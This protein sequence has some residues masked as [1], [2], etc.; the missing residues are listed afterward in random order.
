MGLFVVAGLVFSAAALPVGCGGGGTTDGTGGSSSS[1]PQLTAGEE[2]C[3]TI[4]KYVNKCGSPSPCEQALVDDC[5]KVVDLLSDQFLRSATSCIL[6]GGSPIGCLGSSFTGLTPTEPQK[7][8]ASTF[9]E[10]C[11]GGLVPSCTDLFFGEGSVPEQLQ[12]AGKVILPLG[13][14]LVGKLETDCASAN[15]VTCVANFSNCAQATLVKQALPTN[16]VACLFDSLLNPKPEDQKPTCMISGTGGA[17]GGGSNSASSGTGTSTS[18]SSSS[19]GGNGC[20]TGSDCTQ[21]PDWNGCANCVLQKHLKGAPPYENLANCVYCS[22]CYTTCSGQDPSCFPPSSKD[23]CDG[24]SYSEFE[25]TQSAS[26][27]R[28]CAMAGSCH[29]YAIECQNEPD[30]QAYG[31]E[32]A[33]CPQD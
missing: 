6:G 8:F 32:L 9:C 2:L 16:T 31:D 25:C 19:S 17:G 11:T 26:N 10:K 28:D 7:Q 22:A 13:D 3:A 4:Q 20:A 18:S 12:V 15:P 30:C 21:C 33:K 1:N 23:A 14:A 29:S 24:D 27:C 5:A